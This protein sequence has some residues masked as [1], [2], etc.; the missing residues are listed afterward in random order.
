MQ[1]RNVTNA[2]KFCIIMHAPSFKSKFKLD[3]FKPQYA[4]LPEEFAIYIYVYG[5]CS[6]F[7]RVPYAWHTHPESQCAA[8][9]TDNY[10]H[11]SFRTPT[12][13][14]HVNYCCCAFVMK[15]GLNSLKRHCVTSLAMFGISS[16]CVATNL[17]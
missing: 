11:T 8:L 3:L 2:E 13:G 7:K 6:N 14:K 15:N 1:N 17:R 16:W 10:M 12:S 4:G 5:Y 9:S